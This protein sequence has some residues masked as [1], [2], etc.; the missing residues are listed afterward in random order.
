[1]ARAFGFGSPTG[2]SLSGDQSGRIPDLAFNQ[3]LNKTSDDRDITH[4]ATW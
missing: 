3:A 4:L 2:I 1:M